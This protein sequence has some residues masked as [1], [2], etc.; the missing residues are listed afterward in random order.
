MR[1][2]APTVVISL[3]LIMLLSCGCLGGGQTNNENTSPLANSVLVAR[4]VE[5]MLG[6]N[7]SLSCVLNTT[8]GLG[9][10]NQV[11]YWY[12]DGKP[13]GQSFTYFG[14]AVHN[15]S[16]S[17]VSALST[18]EHQI[19]VEYKGNADYAGS[20]GEG[21]LRVIPKPT[22]T[23]TPSPSPKPSPSPSS[24]PSASPS[25]TPSPSRSPSPTPTASPSPTSK[26]SPT[27]LGVSPSPTRVSSQSRSFG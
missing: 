21:V 23:P 14:F 13:L 24:T 9:L 3:I 10:D 26:T 19:L 11:V 1:Q 8:N 16:V 7:T 5:V 12:L 20:R 25:S 22:P 27:P 2:K 18:G 4:S 17:D 6:Y 15:L